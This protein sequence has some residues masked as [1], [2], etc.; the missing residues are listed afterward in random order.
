M[1]SQGKI[2]FAN[3][4]AEMFARVDPNAL[5]GTNVKDLYSDQ[6]A[7]ERLGHIQEVAR[8]GK[9]IVFEGILRGSWR[10]TSLRLLPTSDGLILQIDS[11]TA[12]A[13]S[14]QQRIRLRHDD[15]GS[16]SGLTAREREILA[17]IGRGLSTVEIAE[18]LGRS[19][20]TIEWH[21]VSLGTKLGVANRVELA[22]IALRA[23]LAQLE[24]PRA[25]H[26]DSPARRADGRRKAVRQDGE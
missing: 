26:G 2:V 23:G 3:R 24:I 20:K 9:T 21:R 13:S 14:H 7:A 16:L 22:H 6:V 19:V 5:V 4:D 17:L 15:L 25:R 8:T 12:P 18:H 10:V 1:T 11:A